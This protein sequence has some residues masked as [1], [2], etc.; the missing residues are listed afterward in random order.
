MHEVFNVKDLGALHYFLGIEV[1]AQSDGFVLTQ[2][3]FTRELL[4]DS[5]ITVFKKALTPLPS[6]LKLSANSGP[7]FSDASLYRSL[8]GKLNFLSH[9]RPDL[10]FA[11]QALSQ[12]MYAP[13]CQH[14][15]ALVH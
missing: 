10:G 13:H 8:V 7:L 3:K 14:Y 11:V 12:F 1:S 15:E 4:K 6:Q 2:S 5:G 9:T